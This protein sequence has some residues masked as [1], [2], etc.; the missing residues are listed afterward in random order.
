MQ[1]TFFNL[2][3]PIRFKHFTRK[4]YALFACLGREVLVGT[5]SVATLSHARAEGVSIRTEEA[6]DTLQRTELKLDEV[7][8]TGSRAPLTLLESAKIVSVITR[9]DVQRAAAASINDILKLVPGVDVRQRGAFGV[10]TDISVRGGNF[11]QIVILLN[12]VPVSSPQ[13]GHLSAD[14]PVSPEDIERI[15]VLEGPVA[16]VY[17]S[18]AFNGVINIVTQGASTAQGGEPFDGSYAHLS[19][20]SYGYANANG[21]IHYDNGKEEGAISTAL[22]GG[23]S[24][25]DDV[26]PNSNFT[27]SRLFWTGDYRS[28]AVTLHAQA[29]YSYKPYAANTFYGASSTDQWESNERIMAAVNADVR[30]GAVHL[31]PQL[32]WNRW[33]DHY[34][35][36]KDNPAGENYHKTDAYGASLNAW[37]SSAIGKTLVGFEMRRE[38]IW[39]TKLGE[40]MAEGD[41]VSSGG[42][43]ANSDIKYK[44]HDSRTNSSFFL[45]H[46]VLLRD[47]TISLGL[48]AN[49]N[50]GLDSKWRLCPGVD[51]SYRPSADWKLTASWNMAMRMPTFTDL[52][53][54]GANIEGNRDL[55]PEKTSDFNVGTTYSH[56]AWS[57]EAQIFYS[58]KTDMIDWVTYSVPTQQNGQVVPVSDGIF[59]SVNFGLDNVGADLGITFRPKAVYGNGFPLNTLSVRYSYIDEHSKYNVT[60]IQSKYAMDYL[61]HKLCLSADADLLRNVNLSA[62]WR[63]HDRTGDNQPYALLDAKLSW[64]LCNN[65]VTGCSTSLYVECTN[66]LNKRYYDYVAIPQPPRCFKAGVIC[67]F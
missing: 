25:C 10:Q 12:G 62:S 54:S 45:E 58:H 63:W 6:A 2:P 64:K 36:H 4:G 46:N 61:R 24:R 56:G 14:F 27:S 37:M 57:V 31:A 34:Q 17:G 29:G 50:S 39:S 20:G 67:R 44:Y 59:H 9:D 13:T 55:K 26:T 8:I 41:W 30:L 3:A 22:S 52:Y 38:A 48:L 11:D 66:I 21:G 23:Y 33:F 42:H 43:D 40:L 47:W 35:W 16:R 28:E 1:Q 60:V 49:R 7:V 65:H 51:V 18:A 5:L 19:G 15:E 53:Y 32:Y